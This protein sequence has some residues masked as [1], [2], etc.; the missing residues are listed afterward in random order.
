LNEDCS[1]IK[2]N[3]K[4]NYQ[5]NVQRS[6]IIAFVK[7][8][9]SG[10]LGDKIIST[11]LAFDSGGGLQQGFNSLKFEFSEIFLKDDYIEFEHRIVTDE[12]FPLS[13]FNLEITEA[14]I[15]TDMEVSGGVL[16]FGN[17]VDNVSQFDF[18]KGI[19]NDFN[20]VLDI[21]G[22]IA[23]IELQQNAENF[24]TYLSIG[25]LEEI[26]EDIT[27][28]I[29]WETNVNIDYL[30]AGLVHLRQSFIESKKAKEVEVLNFQTFG[31][32]LFNLNSFNNKDVA[33]FESF[34]NTCYNWF[35]LVVG[36]GVSGV[37]GA[38]LDYLNK[39]DKLLMWRI[40]T[41]NIFD[42]DQS[43]TLTDLDGVDFSTTI[44]YMQ[45]RFNR[46]S[47]TWNRLFKNTLELRKNNKIK[48]VKLYDH[49]GDIMSFRKK[50]QIRNQTYKLLEF[51]FD[52]VSKLVKAKLQ[53]A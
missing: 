5:S 40:G 19:L 10:I 38:E 34:F 33:T 45:G 41:N 53:L 52:V 29:E 44:F 31:S 39:W 18:L 36:V 32:F 25:G 24:V 50:Y 6:E 15:Q 11:N 46:F 23:R 48:Q 47:Y 2:I 17:Y 37:L 26:I 42:E 28:K 1:N 27:D 21:E 35:D 49:N 14:N 16:W 20:L 4:V 13:N 9:S 51:E 12:S 43:T 30:Q 22:N 7:R 3:L 8:P